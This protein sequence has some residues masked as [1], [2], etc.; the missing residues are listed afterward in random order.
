LSNCHG[1]VGTFVK[2]GMNS[3]P[4]HITL[5]RVIVDSFRLIYDTPGQMQYN[6]TE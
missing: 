5:Y 6:D 4:L 1:D 3:M 2:I